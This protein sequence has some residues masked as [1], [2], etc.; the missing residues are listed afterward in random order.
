[1]DY[2]G[3][4]V[5]MTGIFSSTH[6]DSTGKDYYACIIKDATACCAQGIE[7]ILTD[8]SKYPKEGDTISVIGV[9]DTYN[10][11][12]FRYSTLRD[13]SIV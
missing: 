4:T 11:G 3:K 5:K 2:I 7:F 1:D 9:F 6:D 8:E 13:A 10:E 12:Q